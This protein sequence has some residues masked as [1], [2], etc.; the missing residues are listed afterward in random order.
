MIYI[1]GLGPNEEYSIK[2][3]IRNLLLNTKACIIARTK[4][5]PAI[6]FLYDNKI[7][8]ETC[9]IFYED[10]EE[11]FET[12]NKIAT[13]VLDRA[14][15][16][17]VIYLLPGHPMVAELTTK[18]ILEKS[19]EVKVI[20][21]E[22]FL[23]ICFNLAKFDPVEGFSLLD[24]TNTNAFSNVN[25]KQHLLITQCYDDLTAANISVELDSYYPYNHQVLVMEQVGCANEKVYRAEL[26]ELASVVGEEVN[27][28]RTIYVPPFLQALDTNIKNYLPDYKEGLES[29]SL[30]ENIEKSLENIKV[31]KSDDKKITSEI[32][33]IFK[34]LLDF[35]IVED[36]YIDIDA[37][38]ENLKGKNNG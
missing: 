12:Y 31:N 28:L 19:E 23:D 14:K 18:I 16:E 9:D 11:F 32:A 33:N 2:E 37:L 24:A 21:G 8:Y 7:K 27:N 15:D 6:K 30:I 3:N 10:S 29:N 35:T 22:S 13:Y 36:A 5:H 34:N 25:A 17:D 26:A 1:V 38:L 20:G 4:E